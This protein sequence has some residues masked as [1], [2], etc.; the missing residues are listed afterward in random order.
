LW[1]KMM[2]AKKLISPEDH[3]EDIDE[4]DCKF[5]TNC[6]SKGEKCQRCK[7]NGNRKTPT[8]V[9]TNIPPYSPWYPYRPEPIKRILPYEPFGRR[10]RTNITEGKP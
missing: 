3:F 1:G 2:D 7:H 6:K 9:P 4:P 10:I 8:L 5:K